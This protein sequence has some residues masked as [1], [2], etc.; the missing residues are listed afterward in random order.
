[1]LSNDGF[2]DG[3][4][5]QTV[6][7]QLTSLSQIAAVIVLQSSFTTNL[8]LNLMMSNTLDYT[9]TNASHGTNISSQIVNN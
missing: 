5:K 3:A 2:P 4:C 6:L 8:F 7:N 1:M 9:W